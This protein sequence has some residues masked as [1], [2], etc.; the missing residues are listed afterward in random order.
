MPK[1]KNN[2]WGELPKN[3]NKNTQ[4]R[5]SSRSKR[6]FDYRF[7]IAGLILIFIFI[8]GIVLNSS[9]NDNDPSKVIGLIDIDDGDLK[10][11]WNRYQS[12]DID[13]VNGAKISESGIYHLTG[14]L[15]D[16]SVVIDTGVKGEVKLVL[17]NVSIRNST[18]PAI[19]CLSGDDLVIELVGKNFLEDGYTYDDSL[20]EDISGTIY[21]KADL[22]FKGDGELEIIGNYQ[23][24]IVGKD[25][26]KIASGNYNILATDDGIRGKDSVYIKNGNFYIEAKED[27]IKSTNDLDSGKG[28]VLVEN[29]NIEISAGDDG[30][31]GIQTL[32]VQ[33]GTI[34]IRKSYEGF[35]AQKIIINGGGISISA[36]DDGINAGGGAKNNSDDPKN[37]F[38]ADE[39]CEILINGGDIQVDSGGDGI[40]SNGRVYFNGGK[41]IVNGP[42]NDGNGA[43][44]SGLGIFMNGGEIIALGSSGMAESPSEESSVL[45][46][47]VYFS[48]FNKAGTKFEIKDSNYETIISHSSIKSFTHVVVSTE[49]FIFGNTYTIYLND[50]KYQDFT[51]EDTTTIVGSSNFNTNILPHRR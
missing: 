4:L 15:T 12:K 22:T 28:F 19:S 25:D 17:D 2:F 29:G 51:I 32:A 10:I 23:D 9:S 43:L 34:D 30:I 40:D 27:A 41:T 49:K 31:H 7:F 36:S 24:A 45:N 14:S 46:I 47:S 33:G 39:N 21:S 20:D 18:G 16:D 26:V 44:D 1:A 3:S 38:N 6:H 5:E 13:L 11:N 42:T 50:E 48:N 8:L 37:P 35:E